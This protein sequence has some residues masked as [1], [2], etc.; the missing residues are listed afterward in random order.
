M[1]GK[2][3]WLVELFKL[4]GGRVLVWAVLILCLFIIKW[5]VDA[6]P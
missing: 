4:L 3:N 2:Q 6:V 1:P 5:I